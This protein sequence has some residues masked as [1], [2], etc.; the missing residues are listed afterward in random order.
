[1]EQHEEKA[2]LCALNRIFGFS[3]KIGL[4]LISHTGSAADV[5]RLGNRELEDLLGPSSRHKREITRKAV[6]EASA[7][8]VWLA[9]R[10]ISF[11]GWTEND[12]PSL[13]HECEDAPVGLYVRSKTPMEELWKPCRRIAVVG[14]RDI[15]PYGREWCARTVAGL[16][17]CREKP[18]IVSGLAL[19]TDFCA[20]KAALESG[21]ATIGVMATGPETVYPHRHRE[22]A[23][24]LC[25]TPGCALVTDYP[26]GTAPLAI[27]FL[28]RNRIIA[29]LS[30]STILIE[31]KIKGG[32]MMTCRLAFSYSRDVY[33]LPG[34]AD[35]LRSQGCNSL[36]RSKI[37]EPLTSMEDLTESLGLNRVAVGGKR[38]IREILLCEYGTKLPPEKTEHAISILTRI[39][40]ERGITVEEI[41]EST[42]MSYSMTVNIAAI[43]E[44]DGFISIDLL[45]RCFIMVEKFR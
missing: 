25:E 41:A 18:V 42:G 44:T 27:H 9:N 36:I 21:L 20:H 8:L 45:Q 40:E 17:R 30:D 31:S 39:K 26:P 33:A 23:E 34:R 15:T 6:E 14:T 4:A 13:L 11:V 7:E 19:G 32:G 29:G 10:G 5:F 3:P 28:R 2:C 22:F 1:M 43:L 35:D 24:R 38:S 16:S 12:Y 37:A